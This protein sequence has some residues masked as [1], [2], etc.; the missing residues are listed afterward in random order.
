MFCGG[1]FFE[2]LPR[3]LAC[4]T[5]GNKL[6]LKK[7]KLF[8][9][10]S[11]IKLMKKSIYFR[12]SL[13][14]ILMLAL[15]SPTA[16]LAMGDGKK[17]FNQGMKHETAEEWDKAAEEFALAVTDNPKN[18]EYR[19]HYIRSLFNASQMFMKKGRMQADEKDYA[20]AY[21]SFQKSLRL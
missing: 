10:H 5:P 4:K 2:T 3:I 15:F 18:P 19:L 13:S 1:D 9:K 8:S 21:I 14:F 12:F 11:K 7:V 6:L 20:G 17:H 16:V